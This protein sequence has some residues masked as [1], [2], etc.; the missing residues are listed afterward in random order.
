[1]GAVGDACDDSSDCAGGACVDGFCCD[2]ACDQKCEACSQLVTGQPDGACSA[3][4][5]TTDP[6]A[7]CAAPQVCTVAGSCGYVQ[8]AGG[9]LHTCALTAEGQVR[10]WGQ[11]SLGQMGHEDSDV[12]PVSAA[13]PGLSGAT[14][15]GTGFGFSCALVT[16]GSGWCWGHNGDD[17]LG[18]GAT[19]PT[20]GPPGVSS[21]P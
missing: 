21:L 9:F 16:G 18:H 2:A 6:D 14:G 17:Q 19:T 1:M 8:L 3:V 4:L 11:N 15:L 5:A 7:D 20:I 13:V 12:E 10:C